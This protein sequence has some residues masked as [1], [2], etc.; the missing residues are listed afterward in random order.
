MDII[1]NI[2]EYTLYNFI[3]D[4]FALGRYYIRESGLYHKE[5]MLMGKLELYLDYESYGRDHREKTDGGFT[6]YGWLE[7]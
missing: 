3:H 4:D 6:S 1:E 5:L 7:R 2:N